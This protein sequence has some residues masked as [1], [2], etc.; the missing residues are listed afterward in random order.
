MVPIEVSLM[1]LQFY[2]DIFQAT[3]MF[4]TLEQKCLEIKEF[5]VQGIKALQVKNNDFV[6]K[7]LHFLEEKKK[8]MNGMDKKKHGRKT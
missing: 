1:P 4:Q 3:K 5:T 7:F 6:D 2:D 8:E